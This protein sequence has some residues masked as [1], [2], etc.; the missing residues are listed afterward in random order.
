MIENT[1][2]LVDTAITKMKGTKDEIAAA[3]GHT[4]A[5][6]AK[7]LR[8]ASLLEEFRELWAGVDRDLNTVRS[9]IEA[10]ERI[11]KNKD[12]QE[13]LRSI[14]ATDDTVLGGMGMRYKEATD[15]T[16]QAGR[17]LE[18]VSHSHGEMAVN[19]DSLSMAAAAMREAIPLAQQGIK[20]AAEHTE[21]FLQL[22]DRLHEE[23]I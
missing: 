1:R 4:N 21:G 7:T 6:D 2:K 20:T 18:G 23:D 22:A 13:D 11:L 9:H 3:S 10:N 15:L 5:A 19:V 12:T 16:Q 8:V 14:G 17:I